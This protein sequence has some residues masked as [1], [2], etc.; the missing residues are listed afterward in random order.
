MRIF[1]AD[2][3]MM[4]MMMYMFRMCPMM[5]AQNRRSLCFTAV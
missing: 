1:K 3:F 2:S 4:A 5:C